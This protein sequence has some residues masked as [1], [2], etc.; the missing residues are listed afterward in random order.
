VTDEGRDP[1]VIGAEGEG[2][3]T[4]TLFAPPEHVAPVEGSPSAPE[5]AETAPDEA[6]APPTPPAPPALREPKPAPD[7]GRT[8]A[9]GTLAGLLALGLLLIVRGSPTSSGPPAAASS[10][11]GVLTSA[12]V[13]GSDASAPLAALAPSASA[14]GTPTSA[15][16]AGPKFVPAW[17]VTALE[18]EAGVEI[19]RGTLGKHTL[20]G[21]LAQAGIPKTEIKRVTHSVDNIRRIE[22]GGSKDSFV[23]ARDRTKGTIVAFEYIASPTDV[24][25]AR[26]EET[27]TT[28]KLELFIEKKR[29]QTALV[30]TADLAKAIAAAG[31]HE[32]AIEEIDDALEGHGDTAVVKPGV[33]LR[34]VGHEEWV[35]GAFAR[36]HVDA[37][38]Y[39]PK[40]GERLRVY[41]Y[42]RDPS[43]EGSHRRSP[44]P[45]FYDAKGQQPFRGTFRSPL[46]LAR[47]TSRFN[48]KRMHPVLHVVMPHNG[49]DF[50]ASSG[51]PVYASATG[52]VHSAG[53]GGPCGNMVQIEH[54]SGLTTAYCHLSK[55]AP[56]LH[57]GQHVEARQ[58]VGFVGQTGR[59]T[60]PHLHFAVKRGATFIDPMGLKMDGVRT[61]PP[62][63][64]DAFA[65]KRAELDAALEAVTLPA[66]D[67]AA[68]DDKDDA[69]DEPAGEE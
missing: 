46:P 45:G 33:R 58:L 30:V 4:D 38:D 26:G 3:S 13:L 28:K 49:I 42:E 69:K 36:F 31:L 9:L 22:R 59:A 61:L 54:A 25:Q 10:T 50:G 55:F 44:H 43:V 48:P 52:T 51:T 7:R 11:P 37:L 67:G 65:K 53:D 5:S 19:L 15:P 57:A 12:D 17:R 66:A 6:V 62:A 2:E 1:V 24:W 18:Q 29:T 27:L 20:A 60:G 64:R 35:E 56:G 8:I 63:D 41:Y 32:E 16:D 39:V 68:T 40:T 23:V 34:V 21:A 47:I 14:A